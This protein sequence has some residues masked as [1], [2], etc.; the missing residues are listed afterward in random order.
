M[1]ELRVKVLPFPMQNFLPRVM[2]DPPVLTEFP[3]RNLPLLPRDGENAL[4]TD[5]PEN[6]EKQKGVKSTS[7]DLVNFEKSQG[8]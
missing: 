1:A 7:T 8:L 6:P 5:D 2:G 4:C 3:V